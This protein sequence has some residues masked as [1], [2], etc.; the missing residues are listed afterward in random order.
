MTNLPQS[1]H[2]PSPARF[3]AVHVSALIN[4]FGL[5]C[6]WDTTTRERCPVVHAHTTSV[7]RR[8]RNFVLKMLRFKLICSVDFRELF[9]MSLVSIDPTFH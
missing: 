2:R 5:S 6:P 1:N 7:R 3:N 9:G 4:C 8:A